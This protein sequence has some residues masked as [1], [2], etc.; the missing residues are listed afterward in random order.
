MKVMFIL[1]R[2]HWP[3]FAAICV[4]WAIVAV[5]IIVA[6]AMNQGRL[7]YPLDDTYIHMAI[8][9][10]FALH[11]VWGVTKYEFTSSTS[12]PLW[13]LLLAA[14]YFIFGV[15]EVA[16]LV[17]NL[18]FGTLTVI[19][20]YGFL[21]K[22][23]MNR[24]QLMIFIVLLAAVTATPL[25]ALT[26]IGMEHAL[27]AFLTLCFVYL[28]VTVL[29]SA[30]RSFTLLVALAP[31]VASSRY[32]GL[33]VVFM[34]GV[35]LIIQKKILPAVTIGAAALAP[36]VLYG[37]LSV[38]KGW[39]FFPNSILL[40]GQLSLFSL[41]GNYEPWK[42]GALSALCHNLPLLFL[43][44]LSLFLLAL[45]YVKKLPTGPVDF[46]RRYTLLIFCGTLLLHMQ[47][48]DAGWFYRY[49]AY[50]VLLGIIGAG[51]PIAELASETLRKRFGNR[52]IIH[53][54]A[55]ILL[56]SAFSAPFCRRALGS[57]RRTP[58]AANNTYEQ[59]YQMG[60]FIEKFYQGQ[61]IVLNDIGAATYLADFQLF[62]L[63]GLGS[64]ETARLQLHNRY[65]Y[66]ALYSLLRKQ[67]VS[68]G[69]FYDTLLFNEIRGKFPDWTRIG[70]WII[71]RNLIAADSIVSFYAVDSSAR[72]GLERNLQQFAT[73]LPSDVKQYGGYTEQ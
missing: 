63:W 40:K 39:Y 22:N 33:F 4:M 17:L 35:L 46:R 41:H 58:Q 61:T 57:L 19:I 64:L 32:E 26:A 6:A 47:F 42:F 3:L 60:R 44:V 1:V 49:E 25:P 7:I 23:S 50:L 27:H 53:F 67:K 43:L 2:K 28:A 37:V 34:V 45:P 48:A 24:H 8:A 70:Q 65:T 11:H 18:F 15:N 30:T 10:N 31:F 73:E 12:S 5:L 20:A 59:H 68:I 29:S 56:V 51:A 14:T 72:G 62:D 16:P 71:P 66:D 52:M 21:R 55:A 13:T 69:I 9:K 36:A 38:A 54:T